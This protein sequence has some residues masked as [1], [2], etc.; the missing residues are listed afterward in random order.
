MT[1]ESIYDRDPAIQDGEDLYI[2]ASATGL[3]SRMLYYSAHDV[4]KTDG[5]PPD[6]QVLFDLGNYLEDFAKKTL[7]KH[8][9][10]FIE[11]IPSALVLLPLGDFYVTGHPDA[12]GN[13]DY[14]AHQDTA[15][16]IKVRGDAMF[17]NVSAR[18]NFNATP[19]AVYQL[20]VY[21]RGLLE[22][23]T[24]NPEVDCCIVTMNR[25]TG[26]IHHEW[27]MPHRL[28]EVINVL[29]TELSEDINR[30]R[31]GVPPIT[32]AP[33][34][35]QCT[36]CKW[37]T[38]CGNVTV[39]AVTVAGVPT[40]H[41][42]RA[43]RDWEPVKLAEGQYAMPKEQYEDT[44]AMALAYLQNERMDKMPVQGGS[45]WWNLSLRQK[46]GV[47]LNEEKAR[48]LMGPVQYDSCLEEWEGE[49]YAEIRK[50]KKV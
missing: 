28:E 49:P 15:I 32:L 45:F 3:C 47:K 26:Q 8:H 30:W 40:E 41:L 31:E 25:D 24:I 46:S 20:A 42:A 23:G 37:R 39:D 10:W 17:N 7:V 5:T 29:G 35:Y 33:N 14:T 19:S 16:E 13:H 36:S 27:F 6:T 48:Y 50:G 21:R 12:V 2:R 11:D 1:T 44:R 4:P 38:H 34:N 43:I 18:G 9:G 22:A